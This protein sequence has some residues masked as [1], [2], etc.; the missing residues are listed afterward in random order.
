MQNWWSGWL[1]I[2]QKE[3]VLSEKFGSGISEKFLRG[4]EESHWTYRSVQ[5][6][7]VSYQIFLSQNVIAVKRFIGIV[8]PHTTPTRYFHHRYQQQYRKWAF[9]ILKSVFGLAF[10]TYSF[11]EQGCAGSLF[12]FRIWKNCAYAYPLLLT[13]LPSFPTLPCGWVA[14]ARWLWSDA[15]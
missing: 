12:S 6:A 15:G 8:V 11:T 14:N 3:A 9:R 5:A 7:S 2:I 1:Y 13:T 10:S 4:T